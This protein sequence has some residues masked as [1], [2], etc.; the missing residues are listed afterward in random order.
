MVLV[1]RG[2]MWIW[3]V[4]DSGTEE[5]GFQERLELQRA[6]FSSIG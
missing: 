6:V 2:V 5:E 4:F 1:V 3:I